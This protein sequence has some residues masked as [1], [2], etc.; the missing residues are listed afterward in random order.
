MRPLLL[1]VIAA[2]LSAADKPR[3][4]TFTTSFAERHPEGVYERMRLRYGWGDPEAGALY[5]IAK[6]EFEVTVPADYDGT[7]PY[8]LMVFTSA[9]KGGGAGGYKELLAR[10]RV[11]WIGATNVPNERHVGPRWGLSLDA[12]WNM[13]KAYRIDPRRIYATGFSGGGRCASMVAPT[14]A[15]VFSGALYLCGCNPPEFPSEKPIGKPIRELALGNRYALLTGEKDFNKPGTKT[16]FDNMRAQG[17]K[18]VDYFEQPG[19]EHAMPSAEWFE[20]GLRAVDRPLVEE[21]KALVAQGRG[22]E[23]KKPYEACRAYRQVIEGY[24][25]AVAERTEALDRFAA[26][27]PQ[28]DELLRAEL[29]KLGPASADKQRAFAL[30]AA[31]F[32]CETDAKALADATGAKELAAILAQPG[33]TTPGKL[34]KFRAAWDGYDC[35][36][37]AMEAY[38]GLAAKAL[39]PVA[40]QP[41]GKRGKALLKL[42]KDWQPCPTRERTAALLEEDI[43]PELD[44]IL[45]LD[46]PQARAA[47]LTAF[48]KAWPGTAAAVRAEAALKELTAAPRK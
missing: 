45:A 38:D 7:I 9:G 35:S 44:S 41:A 12:V 15:D 30:R 20:K 17:F 48:C 22:L 47:K 40:A 43:A 3:T 2:L 39:E 14:Y 18:H 19:L 4:G 21:A 42:L 37:K 24:S 36:A 13:A 8:G 34:E 6:E 29:A 16:L 23:A 10:N 25:I 11:I 46:K 5:D 28:V 31:G 33:A 27:S 26:M 1:L 32:P